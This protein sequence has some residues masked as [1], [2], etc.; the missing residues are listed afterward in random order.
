MLAGKRDGGGGGAPGSCCLLLLLLVTGPLYTS[1]FRRLRDELPTLLPLNTLE[2][3]DNQEHFMTTLTSTQQ[4]TTGPKTPVP[5]TPIEVSQ[6]MSAEEPGPDTPLPRSVRPLHYLVRLQ[7]FL[8]GNFSVHGFV[9]V[10]LVAVGEVEDGHSAPTITHFTGHSG[11]HT[12]TAH[13]TKPLNPG[14]R[15]RYSMNFY[16]NLKNTDKG[17]YSVKYKDEDGGERSL[18]ITKFPPSYA[19][20]AFPCF[21]EPHL[22]ATFDIQLARENNMTSVSLMPLVDTS[23]LEGQEGWVV[24]SFLTTPHIPTHSLAFAV[25]S[26]APAR[27][28][29]LSGL[30][31]TVWARQGVLQHTTFLQEFTPRFLTFFEQYFN[32]SYPLTKLDVVIVPGNETQAISSPGLIVIYQE[33]AGMYDASSSTS[34]HKQ[35]VAEVL[36]HE[37]S[38]QWLGNLVT[39]KTWSHIWLYEGLASYLDNVAVSSVESSWSLNNDQVKDLQKALHKDSLSSSFPLYMPALNSEDIVDFLLNLVFQKGSSVVRMLRHCLSEKTFRTGLTN[40]IQRQ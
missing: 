28:T 15:Y 12:F 32:V 26:L 31:I 8:N 20:R 21:D 4:H 38:H 34:S 17:F 23:P 16:S 10:E 39:P 13:L 25:S 3:Q 33:A 7:P 6:E 18:A 5:T 40:F 9:E 14:R 1:A 19:R 27:N 24:D 36:A 30:P 11:V 37:V 2:G 35:H 22:K 29:S